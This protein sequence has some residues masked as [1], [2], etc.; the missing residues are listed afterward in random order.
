VAA[1]VEL[2]VTSGITV[3]TAIW[4]WLVER[5]VSAGK[6]AVAVGGARTV[7][8]A[9]VFIALCGTWWALLR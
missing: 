9:L 5:V 2:R 8:R 1:V 6:V 7:I 3:A 4:S